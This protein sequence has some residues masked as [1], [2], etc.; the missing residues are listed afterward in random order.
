MERSRRLSSSYSPAPHRYHLVR[1]IIATIFAPIVII[2]TATDGCGCCSMLFEKPLRKTENTENV[3]AK[4]LANRTPEE[5][6]KFRRTFLAGLS[7]KRLRDVTGVDEEER[8]HFLCQLSSAQL[9]SL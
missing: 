3:R 2:V 4:N 9:P 5:R 1:I 6:E 8:R 7:G